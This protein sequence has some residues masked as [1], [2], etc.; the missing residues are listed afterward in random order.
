MGKTGAEENRPLGSD[1]FPCRGRIT[2]HDGMTDPNIII[3]AFPPKGL[4]SKP[5]F[6]FF[7]S[8]IARRSQSGIIGDGEAMGRAIRQPEMHDPI[9]NAR[10]FCDDNGFVGHGILY[11]GVSS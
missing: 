1:Q 6:N 3:E 11:S 8:C 7:K 2:T 4:A 10:L 9:L 5:K